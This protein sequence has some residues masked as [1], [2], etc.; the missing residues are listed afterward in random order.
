MK[1]KHNIKEKLFFW[2]N[3][4]KEGASKFGHATQETALGTNAQIQKAPIELKAQKHNIKYWTTKA[5]AKLFPG[6]V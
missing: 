3:K 6:R 4:S 5:K 2:K 1:A